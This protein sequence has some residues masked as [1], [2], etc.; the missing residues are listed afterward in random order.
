VA[1]AIRVSNEEEG[2]MVAAH[3]HVHDWLQL[4]RAEFDEIPDLQLTQR[5]VE[6]LWELDSI[7]GS[8]PRGARRRR[9]LATNAS[10]RLHAQRRAL[11]CS[12][13]FNLAAD[14]DRLAMRICYTGRH[15]LV[16]WNE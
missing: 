12:L 2:I 15:I 8:D 1:D 11:T 14:K 13:S 4:I 10:R 3:A 5:Q 9:I 6:N 7:S 16:T